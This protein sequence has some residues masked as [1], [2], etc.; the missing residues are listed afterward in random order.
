VKRRIR[1]PIVGMVLCLLAAGCLPG[2]ATILKGS[3]QS[4][5]VSTNPPGATCNFMRGGQTFAVANPTPQTVKLD[6][7]V[8]DVTVACSKAGYQDSSGPLQS[9]FQGWTFGNII[10]GGIIGV[11]VDAG[12]GAM[13]DY[14]Q[15]VKITLIPNEFESIADR[16]AFFD[17][18][19]ADVESESGEI[20]KKLSTMCQNTADCDKR[21]AAE[22]EAKQKRLAE[23]E[24]KRAA[25]KVRQ[26]GL[27]S[28][29]IAPLNAPRLRL[30]LLI[31]WHP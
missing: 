25:A 7:S 30:L 3:T 10:F 17:Q 29:Q 13:S 2:C 14:P 28:T 27:D 31:S 11:A 9:V 23:I 15:S 18:M 5:T 12:S 19:R 21:A 26:A 1:P 4:V 22:E 20:L 6:K 16:D 8:K 24:A